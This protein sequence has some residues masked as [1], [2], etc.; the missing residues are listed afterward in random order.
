MG[1]R[2]V[3][4]SKISSTFSEKPSRQAAKSAHSSVRRLL[5]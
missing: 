3:Q 5:W 2:N 4:L 1:S